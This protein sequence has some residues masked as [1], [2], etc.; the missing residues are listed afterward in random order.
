MSA[1]G[2]IK[3]HR[4]ILESWQATR[5]EW[6]AMWTEL[7]LLAKYEDCPEEG[8]KNGQFFSSVF[9]ISKMS[10]VSESNVTR[11][12]KKAIDEGDLIWERSPG[13]RPSGGVNA[14]VS[15]GVLSR[16]TI[17]KYCM[18]QTVSEGV[19]EGGSPS[20]SKRKKKKEVHTVFSKTVGDN[21]QVYD[22]FIQ[23]R[24]DRLQKPDWIPT[25]AQAIQMRANINGM[26]K[27]E[28]LETILVWMRN[29]FADEWQSKHKWSWSIFF[30]DPVRWSTKTNGFQR[31]QDD[32]SN[33][34]AYKLLRKEDIT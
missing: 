6:M 9:N 31:P 12:L 21:S 25:K 28:S 5:P 22:L 10:R 29:Y 14:G 33:N 16:F 20:S 11:F 19:S 23:S 24:Q 13:G 18:Y 32:N 15:G 2:Y 4:K 17:S 3:L 26:L 27:R 7:L 1:N 8:L 34:P 30:S